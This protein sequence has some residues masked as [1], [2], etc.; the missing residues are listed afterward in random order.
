[1]SRP[2]PTGEMELAKADAEWAAFHEDD[3]RE[4]TLDA[5]ADYE[6]EMRCDS[7]PTS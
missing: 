1:M 7:T 5:I 4:R 6:R 2:D 3:H